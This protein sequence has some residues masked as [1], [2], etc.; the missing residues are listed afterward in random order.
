M[1]DKLNLTGS[2]A[3]Y[4]VRKL[5]SLMGLGILSRTRLVFRRLWASAKVC[6]DQ[7]ERF[8]QYGNAP[9]GQ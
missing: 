2:A 5:L 7:G 6:L 4:N 9:L 8:R 3:G 1:G